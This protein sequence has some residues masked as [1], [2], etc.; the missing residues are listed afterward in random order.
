MSPLSSPAMAPALKA[1]PFTTSELDRWLAGKMPRRILVAPY[2][3]PIGKAGFDLD[4]EHFDPDPCGMTGCTGTDFFVYPQ[5]RA[6]RDRLVDF[7]HSTFTSRGST[8]AEQ[9]VKGAIM[10]RVVLDEEPESVDMDGETFAG[11][12]GDF[13]ANAG[14]KR[15]ALIGWLEKRGHPLYGSSQPLRN[16]VRRG[17]AGHLCSWPIQFH[18]ISTSPQNTT[19]VV[20]PLKAV[21]DAP[22]ATEVSIAAL[23]ALYS[24]LD[25]LGSDLRDPS[26]ADGWLG[27]GWAKAGRVLSGRNEGDLRQAMDALR[28]ALARL[29]EVIARQ[30]SPEAENGIIS[31]E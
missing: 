19:A 20:P 5:L 8:P 9:A 12:W 6:N 24:D 4:G 26:A 3:G 14:E 11:L 18:T 27:D 13:W 23:R 1:E 21:L 2:G 30:P 22:D 15:R 29:G 31:S 16:G 25:A 7:H 28:A 10:G 17:K